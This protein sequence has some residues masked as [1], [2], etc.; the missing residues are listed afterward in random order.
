MEYISLYKK[1]PTMG[2]KDG[3]QISE[4][5]AMTSPLEVVLNA[6]ENE[7][8]IL[9]LAIRCADG[10]ETIGETELSIEND[11]EDKWSISLDGADYSKS[12]T[13]TD[14]VKDTNILFYVKITSS[15]TEPP[16][17]NKLVTI[18]C[19]TQ[20]IEQDSVITEEE[21]EPT[22]PPEENPTEPSEGSG[23]EGDSEVTPSEDNDGGDADDDNGEGDEDN[24]SGGSEE[25][26]TE[27]TP[28]NPPEE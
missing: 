2:E 1:N 11:T 19:S 26:P 9:T 16:H 15:N 7:E 24:S 25:T 5:G 17:S 8:K 22:T 13:I 6:S 3:V 10:Y 20:I 14:I 21:E 23:E 28:E 12:I 4:N 18:G 27:E